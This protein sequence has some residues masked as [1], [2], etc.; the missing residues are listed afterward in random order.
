MQRLDRAG[1]VG[2]RHAD[3]L[4]RFRGEPAI[5]DESVQTIG[6]LLELVH[7]FPERLR[8][9]LASRLRDQG[10]RSAIDLAVKPPNGSS[11]SLS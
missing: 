5:V 2:G 4:A 3:D 11:T 6:V 10:L 8:Q 1:Q 7:S 9:R